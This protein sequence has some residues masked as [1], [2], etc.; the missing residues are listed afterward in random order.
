MAH[1]ATSSKDGTPHVVPICFAFDGK[2]FYVSIDDKPKQVEP[3][4]LRRVRNISENPKSRLSSILIEKIGESY[5]M[6]SCKAL[7]K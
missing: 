7:Q 1:L 6:S 4:N 3:K 5:D 2:K